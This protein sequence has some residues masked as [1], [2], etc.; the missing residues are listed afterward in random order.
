M[1][2]LETLFGLRQIFLLNY[3]RTSRTTT[4]NST[5]QATNSE[6]TVEIPSALLQQDLYIF[7]VNF[8]DL[9]RLAPYACFA[10][11]EALHVY[12]PEGY[13]S[14]VSWETIPFPVSHI[15][16][17]TCGLLHTAFHGL[18]ILV[19]H[20]NIAICCQEDKS[21]TGVKTRFY[22]HYTFTC[23]F[24]YEVKPFW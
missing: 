14:L 21:I 2:C 11:S 1:G 19:R 24:T 18:P 6:P 22:C 8:T 5:A 13:Q 7:T 16:A 17:D 15:R 23:L 10:R 9:L 20:C 4:A 12:Y 3:M